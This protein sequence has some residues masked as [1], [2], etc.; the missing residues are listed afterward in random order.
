MLASNLNI[1]ESSSSDMPI[2]EPHSPINQTVEG[3]LDGPAS[4]R[5]CSEYLTMA[6]AHIYLPTNLKKRDEADRTK[7]P[8]E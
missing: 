5:R 6:P 1:Q 4:P 8:P 2:L 7:V 3:G